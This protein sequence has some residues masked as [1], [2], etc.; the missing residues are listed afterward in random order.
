M[1]LPDNISFADGG[2]E[3]ICCDLM[4]KCN[5]HTVLRLATG[6]CYE[7]DVKTNVLFSKRGKTDKFSSVA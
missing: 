4:D 7:Q 3:K 2:G 5:L 1:V 6:I